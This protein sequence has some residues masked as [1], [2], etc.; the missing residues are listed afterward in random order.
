MV[1][2]RKTNPPDNLNQANIFLDGTRLKFEEEAVFLG[3][4]IDSNLNWD[5]HC[6]NVANKISRNN[7]VINRVKNIL[8]PSSLKLLYNSFI[9]PHIH[10]GLPIWG[11]C[12]GQNKQRIIAIQKRA[13]RTITKSY[14]SSHT[15]PRMKKI[16]LLKFDDLYKQQCL[17][18]THDCVNDKAPSPIKQLIEKE[19]ETRGITLRNHTKNP[20][21]LKVPNLKTRVGT[22]SFSVKGPIF[23]NETSNIQK[24]V[25]K[26]ETF[27]NVIKNNI[28]KS[29]SSHC[30]NCNN[31]MCR[32]LRHHQ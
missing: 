18:L 13:I 22:H 27:K 30:I 6:T 9:Q 21:N 15:E 10:Y 2:F 26:R 24:S 23:W 29:Y 5:K 14:H 4:T 7:S 12:S 28:L 16:G 25:K 3:I 20:L 8:P 11:G 17:T 32:D 1:C 19:H 31:P